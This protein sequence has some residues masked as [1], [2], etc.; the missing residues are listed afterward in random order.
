M[1]NKVGRI[2]IELVFIDQVFW[3]RRLSIK[4]NRGETHTGG[5]DYISLSKL[6]AFV[7][8]VELFYLM[9][10]S[11]GSKGK[12]DNKESVLLLYE[13]LAKKGGRRQGWD[14][15]KKNIGKLPSRYL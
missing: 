12:N 7:E 4:K 9:I 6:N 15:K 14:G 10:T 2:V 8:N 1:K 13:I 11:G 3:G 5:I